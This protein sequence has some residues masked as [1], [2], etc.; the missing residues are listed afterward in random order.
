MKPEPRKEIIFM[1]STPELER[2]QEAYFRRKLDELEAKMQN[3]PQTEQPVPLVP[4]RYEVINVDE[5]RGVVKRIED[6][7]LVLRSPSK[8]RLC[9]IMA[10]ALNRNAAKRQKHA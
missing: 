5:E 10:N 1:P 3:E 8:L 4:V 2:Q 6:G 9:H 7:K